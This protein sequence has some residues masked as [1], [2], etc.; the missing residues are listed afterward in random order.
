MNVLF[1]CV[2]NINRSIAGEV[3]CRKHYSNFH[4]V[5]S[6][7]LNGKA[8]R[9]ITGKMRGV[10]RENGYE[11]PEV[12]KSVASSEEL[13]SWADIIFGMDTANLRKMLL[14]Y[15]EH[16]SKFRIIGVPDPHFKPGI[17][18][19]TKAVKTLENYITLCVEL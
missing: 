12:Q 4:D 9:S 15:P 7:G 10:L 2:G 14:L 18:Y 6:C 17:E 1:V 5:K 19:H 13:F 3:I 8:G 11:V 16:E